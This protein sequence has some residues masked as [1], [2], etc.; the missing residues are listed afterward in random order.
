MLVPLDAG[1][2]SGRRH[3]EG[4]APSVRMPRSRPPNGGCDVSAF[5]LENHNYI[6]LH[7]IVNFTV[8][9]IIFVFQMSQDM[10][11]YL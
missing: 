7:C 3:G 9:Y 4:A 11:T 5:N 2:P 6:S 8:R 10:V 1:R